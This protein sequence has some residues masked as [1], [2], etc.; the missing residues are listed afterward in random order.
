MTFD[1]PP[2][3]YQDEGKTIG[4]CGDIGNAIAE[5]AGLVAKNIE[6]RLHRGFEEMKMGRADM[7]ILLASPEAEAVGINMGLLFHE[8]SIVI[9]MAGKEYFSLED[10]VGKKVASIRGA[11]YD[12]RISKENGVIPCPAKTYL[13]C[14]KMLMGGRVDAVLGPRLGLIYTMNENKL[15]QVVFA[16]PLVV[17]QAPVTVYVSRK[18]PLSL[19]KEIKRALQRLMENG[20]VARIRAKYLL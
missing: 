14:L 1:L 20:T 11:R 19:V 12:A 16:K 3:W 18:A 17:S 5:E 4:L 2:Y 8:E 13:Q 9:S 10:L 15:P 7:F 6:G